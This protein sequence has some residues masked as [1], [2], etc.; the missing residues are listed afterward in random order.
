ME[1]NQT[2]QRHCLHRP[3]PV[4]SKPHH[5]RPE[6][7][8]LRVQRLAGIL[9]HDAD[10]GG[11]HE[12]AEQLRLFLNHHHECENEIASSLA[13]HRI[14]SSK[15]CSKGRSGSTKGGS[16]KRTTG[17]VSKGKSRVAWNLLRSLTQLCNDRP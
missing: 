14:S 5:H 7:R 17:N 6:E 10:E 16:P 11:V 15:P 12:V 4:R 2:V 8:R 13:Y 1:P 3:A 9:A